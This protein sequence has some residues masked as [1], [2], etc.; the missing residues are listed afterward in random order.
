MSRIRTLWQAQ[1]KALWR[2]LWRMLTVPRSLAARGAR[3]GLRQAGNQGRRSGVALLVVMTTIMVITV[4][5]TDLAYTARVR[6]LVDAHHT[7]RQQAFWLARSGIEIYNLLILADREMGDTIDQ[8]GGGNL[9]IDGLLD[10]VP[11]IN[12][13]LLTMF[14]AVQADSDVADMSQADKDKLQTTGQVSDEVRKKAV[15]EGGGLFS[16]R[17]WLD[18]PG[19]FTAEVKRE[20]CRININ[21]LRTTQ[22]ATLEESPTYQLMLGRMSGDDNEA[23]LRDHNLT[24]RDL[25]ANLTDW[26]DSDTV[27]SGA[28]GGYE[29]GL[30]QNQEPPYLSKNAPFDSLEEIRLVDGWQDDVYDRFAEQFTVY[31][32]GKLNINCGDDQIHWAILHSSFVKN[33]PRTDSQTQEDIDLINEQKMLG[34]IKKPKDYVTFLNGLGLQVD[35]G[36]VNILTDKSSVFRITSTGMVAE[37]AV[38]IT[39]V[40]QFDSRGRSTLLYHRVD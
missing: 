31:G 11:Q 18:M 35:A 2:M 5:V 7:E 37:S 17:S 15:D 24:A 39:D 1:W 20:D 9:A 4:I 16:E 21:L 23:W 10:M 6:F 27:R 13:G 22:A 32:S 25:V 14:T 26:V 3:V 33:P 12:T 36:L 38:T 28:R 34:L 19:D 29:D 30:Y 40:V 8:L